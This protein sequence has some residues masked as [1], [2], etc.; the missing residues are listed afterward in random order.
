M[1]PGLGLKI[2]SRA[3]DR[4]GVDRGDQLTCWWFE[5]DLEPSGARGDAQAGDGAAHRVAR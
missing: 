5:I 3:T 4:W 2:V 1:R